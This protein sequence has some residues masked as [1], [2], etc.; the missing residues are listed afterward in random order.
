[1][2]TCLLAEKAF[3][4]AHCEVRDADP[5]KDT[6]YGSAHGEAKII[7]IRFD[8]PAVYPDGHLKKVCEAVRDSLLGGKTYFTNRHR[9]WYIEVWGRGDSW[10]LG[11]DNG[12]HDY[13]SA[14]DAVGLNE[15]NGDII[16]PAL[17]KDGDCDVEDV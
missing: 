16:G 2:V 8:E 12:R 11:T 7:R 13:R 3:P 4:S 6:A 15:K 17:H 1:M 9:H 5:E 10:T 14:Q